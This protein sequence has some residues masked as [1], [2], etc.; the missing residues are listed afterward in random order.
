MSAFD[1]DF[2]MDDLDKFEDHLKLRLGRATPQ[3]TLHMIDQAAAFLDD[4]ER[5]DAN[6]NP[7][8]INNAASTVCRAARVLLNFARKVPVVDGIGNRGTNEVPFGDITFTDGAR[9]GYGLFDGRFLVF[10]METFGAP[11][12]S[13]AHIKAAESYIAEHYVEALPTTA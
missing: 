5:Y 12:P 13:L 4:E 9:V 7:T 1:L 11:K 10:K 8:H 6:V 3:Q 2:K